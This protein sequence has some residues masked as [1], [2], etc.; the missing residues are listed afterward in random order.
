M[1]LR[2]KMLTTPYSGSIDELATALST[3]SPRGGGC[4]DFLEEGICCVDERTPDRTAMR[5][6]LQYVFTYA[7][8]LDHSILGSSQG[9]AGIQNIQIQS[10]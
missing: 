3:S 5:F 4:L 10:I 1:R 7:L 9:P 8:V 2:A 6:P